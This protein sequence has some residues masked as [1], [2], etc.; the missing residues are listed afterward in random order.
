[1]SIPSPGRPA[2]SEFSPHAKSYVDLVPD[3]DLIAGLERQLRETVL[4]LNP[5][6][7]ASAET[8]VY[9]PGKWSIKQIV[10]HISDAERIFAT[11][12]LRVARADRTP[13]P[14]FEQ[15]DY[16]AS[17]ASNQRTLADLLAEYESVRN[18]TL[19]LLRSLTPEAWLRVGCANNCDQSVRGV[20]Y[21]LAG[22]E[23]HHVKILRERYLSLLNRGGEVDSSPTAR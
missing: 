6:D 20:A 19:T 17:A 4:L 14:G 22:H 7:D 11:R 9:E 18:A 10:G 13:L 21:T 8:L 12:I 1:M 2:P 23:L 3:G 16:V 5:V 15:D